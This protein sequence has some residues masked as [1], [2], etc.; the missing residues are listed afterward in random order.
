MNTWEELINNQQKFMTIWVFLVLGYVL[1]LAL[2]FTGLKILL[3][4]IYGCWGIV[5]RKIFK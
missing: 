3:E 1:I 2:F 4:F 5:K